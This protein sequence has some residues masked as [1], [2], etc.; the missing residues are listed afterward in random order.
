MNDECRK[1][2]CRNCGY[3]CICDGTK[4]GKKRV[5]ELFKKA[6]Q[7]SKLSGVEE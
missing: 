1:E 2:E 7:M 5:D 3:S 4:E 6:E